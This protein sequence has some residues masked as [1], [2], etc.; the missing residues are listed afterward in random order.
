MKKST[1]GYQ[2]NLSPPYVINPYKINKKNNNLF[3]LL[4]GE[5]KPKLFK[6]QHFSSICFAN[7]KTE[8]KAAERKKTDFNALFLNK[9]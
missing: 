1:L 9:M 3:L 2:S 4:K 8:E 5:V 6:N 7:K